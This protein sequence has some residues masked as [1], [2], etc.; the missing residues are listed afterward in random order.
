[1]ILPLPLQ[2][3]L[4]SSLHFHPCFLAPCPNQPHGGKNH[5]MLEQ[6]CKQT[7]HSCKHC[8]S[9]PAPPQGACSLALLHFCPAHTRLSCCVCFC[10]PGACSP[11]PLSALWFL[12]ILF[13]ISS[14]PG[15]EAQLLH[16]QI[17][18]TALDTATEAMV[19]SETSCPPEK[20]TYP[21]I[22][23]CLCFYMFLSSDIQ[24]FLPF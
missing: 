24:P 23:I 5:A 17:K 9:L 10:A 18:P 11:P 1:M 15:R 6:S 16:A 7:E 12:F 20:K 13:C 3:P 19:K 21:F 8:L 2:L 22:S 4:A 14:K